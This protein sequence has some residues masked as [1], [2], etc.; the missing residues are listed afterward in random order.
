M[1]LTAEISNTGGTVQRFN[2]QNAPLW[3]HISPASGTIE[4]QSTQKITLDIDE[5]LNVGAYDEVVHLVN[6][7]NVSGILS[8]NIKVNGEKPDWSVNPKDYKYNMSVYGKLRIN[9]IFSSDKNDIIAAFIDG[10]CVGVAGNEYMES[11]DFWYT[12]ITVYSNEPQFENIE[13]RIWDDSSGKTYLAGS[14]PSVSFNANAVIGTPDAPV[15]FDGKEMVFRNYKIEQ[16]WNWISFNLENNNLQSVN[17][18]LI[19]GAWESGDELKNAANV[20]SY[21]HNG[22][23]KGTISLNN[24]LNNTSM[25]MLKSNNRQSLSV[26]GR[27]LDA[28]SVSL[29]INPQWNYISY[30]PSVNMTVKEALAGYAAIKGDIIKSQNRFAMYSD[31][32]GWVGNLTYMESGKGYM[33]YRNPS[34]ATAT[35][36]YPSVSGSLSVRSASLVPENLLTAAT[37]EYE[38]TNYAENMSVIAKVETDFTITGDYKLKAYIDGELRG[39]SSSITGMHSDIFGNTSFITISGEQKAPVSF[40]LESNGKNVATATKVFDYAS[41]AVNGSIEEPFVIRFSDMKESVN[42]YPALFDREVNISV[43]ASPN[44]DVMV[45]VF[46]MAGETIYKK[47]SM[48]GSD[49]NV[50]LR[51][52]GE[53][54]AAGV[55]LI[56]VSVDGVKTVR[57]VIK[58]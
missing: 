49:G 45:V 53:S 48:T 5:G 21:S 56:Q 46:S 35:F 37:G 32:Q 4:P 55:Y 27:T 20:D 41:N 6:E 29:T 30:I 3:L 36:R 17:A 42:V 15:I 13:F 44:Q 43:S 18:T 39:V 8:L 33:L 40:V 57:K 47:H 58:K 38:N 25:Y 14:N 9:N 52:D 31:N 26:T 24:D 12:F 54:C 51:W 16:G 34:A 50:L 10:K 28:A 11:A 23:W 2:I 1:T 19:N 22:G 7:S